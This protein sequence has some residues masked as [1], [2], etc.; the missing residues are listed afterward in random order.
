MLWFEFLN[1]SWIVNC[2]TKITKALSLSLSLSLTWP[3]PIWKRHISK[4]GLPYPL[5][6]SLSECQYHYI[7]M[8]QGRT[9][10]ILCTIKQHT[11][12]KGGGM[13][14][15]VEQQLPPTSWLWYSAGSSLWS[16]LGSISNTDNRECWTSSNETIWS[17]KANRLICN[18]LNLL[19]NRA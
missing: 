12:C 17:W 10:H 13:Q 16:A 2:T 5:T 8:N 3:I 6:H 19:L 1:L 7:K 14:K 15:Q 9:S 18:W 4:R 11:L